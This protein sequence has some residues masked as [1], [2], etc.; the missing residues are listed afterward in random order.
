M[1]YTDHAQRRL[2]QRCIRP[3]VV[4]LLQTHGTRSYDGRGGVRCYFDR[5]TRRRLSRVLGKDGFKRISHKL[6][7]YAV[8]SADEST[9]ITVGWRTKRIRH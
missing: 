2:E 5:S 3:D 6:D 9:V 4:S 8:L 7:T 1:E